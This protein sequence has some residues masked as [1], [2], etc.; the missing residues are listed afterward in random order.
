[1][2]LAYSLQLIIA[3]I[4]HSTCHSLVVAE[5]YTESRDNHVMSRDS[6]EHIRPSNSVSV[7][8]LFRERTASLL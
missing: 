5:R 6:N 2:I 3:I 4:L 1:M 7:H 8:F